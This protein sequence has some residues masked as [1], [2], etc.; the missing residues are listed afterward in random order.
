MRAG[1][2]GALTQGLGLIA[3]CS[4]QR[5]HDDK[6]ILSPALER[7]TGAVG[8]DHERSGSDRSR[9]LADANGT[10]SGD[11]IDDF[12]T[13]FMDVL[14]DSL[15]HL[16]QPDSLQRVARQNR[17]L[18]GFPPDEVFI[19]IINNRQQSRA[20]RREESLQAALARE[21]VWEAVAERDSTRRQSGCTHHR[22]R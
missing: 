18:E 15:P 10:L 21:R 5:R 6:R 11:D 1:T 19:E 8:H 12:V 9:R 3:G 2:A 22:E 20:D 13:A 16:Q 7:V 4:D 14:R 17:F